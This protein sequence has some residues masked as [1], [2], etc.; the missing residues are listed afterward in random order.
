MNALQTYHASHAE[1]LAL[2]NTL[3][4]NDLDHAPAIVLERMKHF[5]DFQSIGNLLV[6]TP[7]PDMSHRGQLADV[8]Q[9]LGRMLFA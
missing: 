7:M 4:D 3:S 5:A 8:R 2:L 9:R 1:T 6:F